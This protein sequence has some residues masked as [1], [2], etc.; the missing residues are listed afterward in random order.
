MFRYQVDNDTHLASLELRHADILHDVIDKNRQH[1]GRFLPFAKH[2]TL[3]GTREFVQSSLHRFAAGTDVLSTIWYRNQLVGSIG[4]HITPG[5]QSASIG[6][7]IAEEAQGK[8]IMTKCC[9]AVIDYAF[10]DLGLHRIEIRANTD[11]VKSRAIPERLGFK[12]EGILRQAFKLEN[13]F[14]DSV[15]YGLLAEEWRQ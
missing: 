10:D 14:A 12:Q 8:G 9:Q 1:I 2:Q 3:E 6:Y 15:V 5:Q 7:W 4:L 13:G 11:N